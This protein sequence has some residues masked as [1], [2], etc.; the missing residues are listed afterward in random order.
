MHLEFTLTHACPVRCAY[1]PQDEFIGAYRS[2]VG[3]RSTAVNDFK[4][5]LQNVNHTTD[6]IDFSG[7]TDS[8]RNPNWYEIFLHT[9]EEGYTLTLYSTFWKMTLHDVDRLTE[10]PE[11]EMVVHTLPD[12]KYARLYSH[13]YKQAVSRRHKITFIY[14]TNEE[15]RVLAEIGRGVDA[16]QWQ[17][18]S[19]AGKLEVGRTYLDGPVDCAEERYRS[20]VV[21]PNGDVHICCMDFAL[22]HKVGNLLNQTLREI[23]ASPR[24]QGFIDR[25]RGA[26]PSMCNS[27]IYAVPHEP[28]RMS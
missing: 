24:V 14:F 13:L 10:L 6:N 5:M 26:A 25:M 1:C 22:E 18:H 9:L 11:F 27:C 21:L 4:H 23:Q 8:V 17:A 28:S 15:E 19:R 2:L 20:N 7:Y 12:M 16:E 3:P